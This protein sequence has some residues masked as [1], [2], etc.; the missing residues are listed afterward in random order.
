MRPL[1]F[2][3]VMLVSLFVLC[4]VFVGAGFDSPASL[5]YWCTPV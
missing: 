3:F 4:F 2:C 1:L 5:A